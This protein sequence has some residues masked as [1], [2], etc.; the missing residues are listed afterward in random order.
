VDVSLREALTNKLRALENARASSSRG[1]MV[2]LW[3]GDQHAA[4]TPRG[5]R[6][7]CSR[8]ALSERAR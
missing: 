5:A 3:F 1:E 6:E 2:S 7:S 4:A 8:D